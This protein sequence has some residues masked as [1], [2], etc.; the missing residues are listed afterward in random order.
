MWRIGWLIKINEML[1][2]YIIIY[3]KNKE[4]G[5]IDRKINIFLLLCYGKVKC[6]DYFVLMELKKY[7]INY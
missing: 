5:E 2:I 3:I 4:V 1:S 6:F 7:W